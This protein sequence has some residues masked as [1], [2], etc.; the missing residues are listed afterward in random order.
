ARFPSR[1]ARQAERLE[2]LAAQSQDGED[3]ARHARPL[4]PRA[5]HRADA[6]GAGSDD[7]ARHRDRARVRLHPAKAVIRGQGNNSREGVAARS[8]YGI[9]TLTPNYFAV[10]G[11]AAAS[12]VISFSSF[13]AS[14]SKRRMPSASLS[15]AIA[16]SLCSQR[17]AASSSF[18]RG[19]SACFAFSGD[20]FLSTGPWAAES[21]CSRSGA[22]VR[23]SQPASARI[24]PVLRKLAPITCVR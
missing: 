16:S 2:L 10:T 3:R 20:S 22:M 4:H 14:A 11:V 19:M 21:F 8:R 7:G 6:Q 1:R 24:W 15:L 23:R 17:N 13:L 9:V 5:E 12:E 18:T